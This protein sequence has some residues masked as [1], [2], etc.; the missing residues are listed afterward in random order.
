MTGMDAEWKPDRWWRVMYAEER[1]GGWAANVWCETSDET[2]AREALTTCPGG[3]KLL[4]LYGRSESE[5]R[6]EP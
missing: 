1:P 5:W 2:E 3:G 4:R 6:A